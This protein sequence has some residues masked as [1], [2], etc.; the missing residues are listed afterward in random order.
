MF[1]LIKAVEVGDDRILLGKPC[2]IK[3]EFNRVKGRVMYEGTTKECKEIV[4]LGAREE[5]IVK[6]LNNNPIN[7]KEARYGERV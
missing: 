2:K 6:V 5:R 7:V 1:G 4:R 3:G